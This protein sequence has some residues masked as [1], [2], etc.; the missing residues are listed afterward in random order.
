MVVN[1]IAGVPRQVLHLGG[2]VDGVL[3]G[4]AADFKQLAAAGK[5]RL[6]DRENRIT[7]LLT[8]FRIGLH[9]LNSCVV[10]RCMGCAE[11]AQRTLRGLRPP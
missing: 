5:Q 2:E 9:V 4:A 10:C 3:A 1:A 6:D 11:R 7:V 8:G